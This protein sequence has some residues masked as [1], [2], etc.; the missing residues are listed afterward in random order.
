M[1]VFDRLR[2]RGGRTG[3]FGSIEGYFQAVDALIARLESE[4]HGKAA[5]EAI[6][7]DAHRAVYRR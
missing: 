5:E 1:S 4:G 2:D 6:R 7:A 3:L